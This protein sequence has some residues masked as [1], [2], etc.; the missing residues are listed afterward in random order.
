MPTIGT[1]H[2]DPMNGQ[3]HPA[4]RAAFKWWHGETASQCEFCDDD[5][6]DDVLI[7]FYAEED[8]ALCERHGAEQLCIMTCT[9]A[10]CRGRKM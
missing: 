10:A 6:D 4:P 2:R 9:D 3:Y 5:G 1:I 8:A 7:G